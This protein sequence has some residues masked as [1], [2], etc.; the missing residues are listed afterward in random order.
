MSLK[1][2]AKRAKLAQ[3]ILKE[4]ANLPAKS[5]T[6]H[7]RHHLFLR[8]VMLACAYPADMPKNLL[9]DC[10]QQLADS[11]NDE[12]T[13]FVLEHFPHLK[14]A[15]VAEGMHAAHWSEG[16]IPPTNGKKKQRCTN[17]ASR[18]VFNFI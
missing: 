15:K 6:A 2:N 14:A 18:R 3:S 11:D 8:L 16:A 13:E 5:K 17:A 9:E 12:D 1:A 10:A 7:K 4:L